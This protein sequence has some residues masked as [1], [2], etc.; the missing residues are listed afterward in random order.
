MPTQEKTDTKTA[1]KKA[2][3]L[4]G[5]SPSFTV[6]DLDKSLSWY[7]DVLGFDVEERWEDGG[8]LMGVELGAGDVS[9]FIGQDDW[10]KG[11]DRVKGE[12]FRLYCQT[13]QNIDELAREI[14]AR[15]GRL[16][17]EPYDEPWGARALTVVDPDGFKITISK[18]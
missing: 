14:K 4:R 10:K 3:K 18:Q 15:G 1:A 9:F 7:T 6:N 13:T 17:D 2:L 5:A 11:R 16:L 8:T 12:G